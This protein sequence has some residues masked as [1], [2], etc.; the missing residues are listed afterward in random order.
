MANNW[1]DEANCGAKFDYIR[2][3]NDKA[4]PGV[5]HSISRTRLNYFSMY[6]LHN[7][8]AT[9]N[10]HLWPHMHMFI[11]TRTCTYVCASVLSYLHIHTCPQH[12]D[13]RYTID[14]RGSMIWYSIQSYKYTDKTLF[15]LCT[16]KRRPI[17]NL[18]GRAVMRRLSF[19]KRTIMMMIIS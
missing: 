8:N 6:D 12:D 4:V 11:H 13:R 17:E 2:A 14:S 10:A 16:N 15:R 9:Y 7:K 18:Y 5:K 1:S 19:I 3:I